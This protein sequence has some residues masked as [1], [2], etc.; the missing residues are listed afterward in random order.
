MSSKPN[1]HFTDNM[2]VKTL[3]CAL[4]RRKNV[5]REL[6]SEIFIK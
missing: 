6:Y 2:L 5:S 3:R 1:M 4:D